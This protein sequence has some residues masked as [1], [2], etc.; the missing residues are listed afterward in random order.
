MTTSEPL[1]RLAAELDFIGRR[2]QVV[3]QELQRTQVVGPAP[4]FV[5]TSMPM[6]M[7][8]PVQ[9][10]G[11]PM[12]APVPGQMPPPRYVPPPPLP[13][14]LGREGAGS[15]VVAWVGGSVT[16]LG[17]VLL[18]VLAVQRGWLGPEPRVVVGGGLGLALIAG[19]LWVHRNPAGRSGA[20]ALAATGIAVLYLDIAA[21][22]SLYGLMPQ[23]AGLLVALLV[24]A[25]GLLLAARWN[26]QFIAIWVIL[27]CA[28][29]DPVLTH[30]FTALLVAFLVVLQ[31]GAMP[32]QLLRSWPALALVAG[33]PPV[34]ASLVTTVFSAGPGDR[35]QTA[36]VA[37]AA[38]VVGVAVAVV[39][40]LRDRENV[41]MPAILLA[42]A[43]V[44]ALV[45]GV[46]LTKSEATWLAVIVAVLMLAVAVCDRWLGTP[47]TVTAAVLGSVAV[48][49]A[50]VHALTGPTQA[51]TLLGESLV[52]VLA[53]DLVRHRAALLAALLTG[54]FG[55]LW[56]LTT[57][58]PA[59]LVVYRPEQELTVSTALTA[60]LVAV[61]AIAIPLVGY[62]MKVIGAP[63]RQAAPWIVAGVVMLYGAAGAVLSTA[64]L[65]E[66]DRTGFV[67]GH[68]V[69]TVSWTVAAIALLLLGVRSAALRAVGLVLVG[70][71]VVK[72]ILFD[73]ATLDGLARVLA[74]L[75]AG[76]LLL[77][78]GTR[79][80]RLVSREGVITD[81]SRG[82]TNQVQD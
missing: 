15:K 69:I 12:P 42:T 4:S 45:A 8:V 63:I 61:V 17:I 75:A 39:A 51:V 68:A 62:R 48:V 73:L 50:T 27:G 2:L 80:A 60:L 74:F 7:P 38:T 1:A 31:I 6:P 5:Q 32:A 10:P 52:L 77:L 22:T 58:T 79:Y 55:L 29:C 59:M 37:L 64:L 34:L 76:L 67:F 9:P 82:V 43:P 20:Y 30:G 26:A 36:G 21:A 57:V 23:W 46:T 33:I 44:A 71:A 16:L 47:I 35:M 54:G 53:A 19:G 78:A 18:M 11:A 66:P 25:G 24:A 14:R 81:E 28:V 40:T 70:A 41:A 65:I 56:G 49:D 72:L 3:S 13:E